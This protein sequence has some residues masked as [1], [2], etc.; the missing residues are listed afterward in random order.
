MSEQQKTLALATAGVS[1]Y[2][3]VQKFFRWKSQNSATVFTALNKNYLR[4]PQHTWLSSEQFAV[5]V[6]LCD[7]FIPQLDAQEV[8]KE[9]GDLDLPV[10]ITKLD[11]NLFEKNI[12]LLRNGALSRSVHNNV[13]DVLYRITSET[14]RADVVFLLKNLATSAGCFLMTGFAAPYYGLTL[15]NRIKAIQRLQNSYVGDL[16]IG[17]QVCTL[18]CCGT[19]E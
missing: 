1:L 6:A 11:N 18:V 15:K 8:Y 9:Y 4:P 2:V 12:Q 14:E 5:L 13:C 7:A 10:D 3:L 17:Y 16:R 19:R